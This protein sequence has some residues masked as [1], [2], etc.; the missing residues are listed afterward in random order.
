MDG[1]IEFSCGLANIG[2]WV[3][4]TFGVEDNAAYALKISLSHFYSLIK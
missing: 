3:Y 4:I 2:D 1:L